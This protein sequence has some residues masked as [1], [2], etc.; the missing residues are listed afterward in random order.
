MNATINIL[1]KFFLHKINSNMQKS[2]V[3]MIMFICE[4]GVTYVEFKTLEH[5]FVKD[6]HKATKLN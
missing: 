5:N 6:D 2:K 4:D 1:C 3:E